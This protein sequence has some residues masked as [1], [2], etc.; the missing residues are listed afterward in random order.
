MSKSLAHVNLVELNMNALRGLYDVN[1]AQFKDLIGHLNWKKFAERISEQL[2]SNLLLTSEQQ[3]LM[4]VNLIVA[5]MRSHQFEKAHELVKS[6][7]KQKSCHSAIE[8]LRVFF[9]LKEKKYE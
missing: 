7:A 1:A 6:A 4:E 9:L 5:L 8:G 3:K 2:R